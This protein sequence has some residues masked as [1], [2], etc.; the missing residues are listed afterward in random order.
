MKNKMFRPSTFS[1]AGAS[2]CR[3]ICFSFFILHF[4]LIGAQSLSLDDCL[5]LAAQGSVAQQNARLDVLAAQAQRGEAR[6]LWFPTV[7]ARVLGFQAFSPLL[8]IGLGDVLGHSDGAAVLRYY[9]E[10]QAQLYGVNTRY[11]SLLN[12]YTSGLTLTQPLYAGGRIVNGNRLAA[13]G[14]EAATLKARVTERDDRLAVEQK[15]WLVVS[16]EDKQQVLDAA[17]ALLDT[18]MRDVRSAADAGLALT[19][20]I[21][22]VQL[23]RDE[24]VSDSLRLASGLRLARQDLLNTIGATSASPLSQTGESAPLVLTTRLTDLEAPERWHVPEAQAAASVEEA[25]LLQL[26]VNAR[27]LERRIALGEALPEV[28]LG[29]AYGYGRM[30]GTKPRGNGL[31]F[32]TVSIPLTDWARTLQRNRRLDYAVQ[33]AENEQTTLSAQLELRVRQA[34][35][36]L[37]LCW[38]QLAVARRSIDTAH[39]LLVQ[40]ERSRAAGITTTADH[41]QAELAF[42]TA[43]NTLTDRRIAYAEAL[44]RYRALTRQ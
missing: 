44:A 32:A 42:R 35:D 17:L 4:S 18:L 37:T 2:V 22:Q 36:E 16:L 13:L 12:G 26:Q 10:T 41:L 15:Y 31:V 34:W 21:M 28:A 27:Q 23:R 6:T 33:Q 38:Q 19:S 1:A 5:T 20:D 39:T 7:Q 29:A 24:L 3:A 14:V 43:Q 9:V 30:L 11:T 25:R 8:D 40:S